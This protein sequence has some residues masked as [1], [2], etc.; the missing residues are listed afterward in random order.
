[1]AAVTNG[2]VMMPPAGARVIDLVGEHGLERCARER[3]R[4]QRELPFE[5]PARERLVDAAHRDDEQR[6]PEASVGGRQDRNR[7]TAPGGGHSTS[8]A[9]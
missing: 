2:V 7:E 1:M 4:C 3:R 5:D 6:G 8:L 9:R